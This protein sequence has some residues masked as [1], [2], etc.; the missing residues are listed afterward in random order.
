MSVFERRADLIDQ[1]EFKHGR[2]RGRLAA[3]MDLLTDLEVLIG[4]HAAYCAA[5]KKTVRAP[6]DIRSALEQV[7]HTKELVASLLS[8]QDPVTGPKKDDE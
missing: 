1:M 5:A 7:A 6:A 2:E 8:D 4:S 3:A